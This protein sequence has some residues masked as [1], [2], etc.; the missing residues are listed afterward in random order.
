MFRRSICA[1]KKKGSENQKAMTMV[2]GTVAIK[3]ARQV[4]IQLYR[5]T[6]VDVKELPLTAAYRQ[7]FEGITRQRLSKV[8]SRGNPSNPFGEWH[9]KQS[10]KDTPL[11]LSG[12]YFLDLLTRHV[13]GDGTSIHSGRQTDVISRIDEYK[14]LSHLFFG[15]SPCIWFYFLRVRFESH[16]MSF[17]RKAG[18]AN[19][20]SP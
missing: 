10:G 7:N 16:L 17:E 15:Q 2:A 4:L 6:L 3:N 20:Q 14:Y 11:N 19:A 1:F 13:Q 5:K 8:P 9:E 18:S 12:N